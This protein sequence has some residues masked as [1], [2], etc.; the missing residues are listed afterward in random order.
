MPFFKKKQKDALPTATAPNQSSIQNVRKQTPTS[1]PVALPQKETQRHED[2]WIKKEV[3]PED[4]QE[5]LHLCTLA[6]KQ[7]GIVVPYQEWSIM[8]TQLTVRLGLDAPFFFLPFRPNTV[9]YLSV[10]RAFIRRFFREFTSG[11]DGSIS[12]FSEEVR[13]LEPMVR[14][15]IAWGDRSAK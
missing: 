6:L 5:L 15:Q 12:S 14:G 8:R 3:A 11:Q 2:G 1:P 10:T 4:V 7:R 13:L 9:Q